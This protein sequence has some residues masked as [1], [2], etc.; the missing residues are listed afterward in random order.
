MFISIRVVLGG[1]QA[2]TV[3]F[4]GGGGTNIHNVRSKTYKRKDIPEVVRRRM[5]GLPL[6]SDVESWW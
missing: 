4:L 5:V 6:P 3:N 1:Y 2:E